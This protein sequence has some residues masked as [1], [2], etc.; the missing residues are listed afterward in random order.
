[1]EIV[2]ADAL[3][4]LR[5]QSR[6]WHDWK[7]VANLPYA[8][9]SP[10]LVELAL[11]EKG[12]LRMVATLQLEV[13]RRLMAAAGNA[14]Y[15]VLTL[16]VQLEY[17]PVEWFKIPAGCFFPEPD[18]DSACV[19]LQRRSQPL[20]TADRRAAFVSIVKRSFSQR[21]KMMAK[22]LKAD[23]PVE[24]VEHAFETVPLPFG[25]RAEKVSLEQFVLLTRI[26]YER[27]N[28]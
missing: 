27:R 8:V 7:L 13:A 23:W 18:V 10:I 2:E 12:P 11:N 16:L 4:Y 1:M 25:I 9:A 26:L 22:L 17:L 15:G 19:V 24:S 6:D 20:L 5:T 14:D 3:E 21:R 28:L